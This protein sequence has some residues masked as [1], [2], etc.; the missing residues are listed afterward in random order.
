[1]FSSLQPDVVPLLTLL[2]VLMIFS[3]WRAARNLW[4]LS[5]RVLVRWQ[6]RRSLGML[7][8]EVED[9]RRTSFELFLQRGVFHLRVREPFRA[10]ASFEQATRAHPLSPQGYYGQGLAWRQSRYFAASL[11]EQTLRAALD[12]DP[13]HID[14]RLLLI[15]FYLQVGEYP[16]AQEEY[17]QLPDAS[18]SEA[19]ARLLEA[20][21][22]PPF[23]PD[24]Q[25]FLRASSRERVALKVLDVAVAALLGASVL[26]HALLLPGV[27]LLAFA[28]PLHALRFWSLHADA[29]G[30]EVRTL[31]RSRQCRWMDVTDLVEAPQGGFF[32]QTQNESLF[33]S[34]R[35]N[36]YSELLRLIKHH[37]YCRGWVPLM[38]EYG[39]RRLA[40]PLIR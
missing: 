20:P 6:A 7:E 23:G 34:S 32:L 21:A 26:L 24:P 39:R 4:S 17:A 9:G 11:Q 22:L 28:L 38:R 8:A 5:R 1:M 36:R 19:F 3:A 15:D 30:L 40:R 33:I 18:R 25:V 16:A 2:I 27:Y 14:A 35:W 10:S 31:R 29:D 12:R 13:G 37:L